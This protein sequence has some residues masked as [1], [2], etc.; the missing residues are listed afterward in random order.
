VPFD[1]LMSK[2]LLAQ[3]KGGVKS[4]EASCFEEMVNCYTFGI[5]FIVGVE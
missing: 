4:Y 2:A 3:L 1:I 5:C